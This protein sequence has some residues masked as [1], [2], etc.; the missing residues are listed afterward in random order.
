MTYELGLHRALDKIMAGAE[1]GKVY[2]FR[3]VSF[4]MGGFWP[5]LM[6]PS[7]GSA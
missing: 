2:Q 5:E 1:K 3:V 6:R 4:S 7:P